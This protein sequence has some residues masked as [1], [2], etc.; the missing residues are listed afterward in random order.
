MGQTIL[1]IDPGDTTGYVL[2]H[3]EQGSQ[4]WEVMATGEASWPNLSEL[5]S[6][7]QYRHQ[8]VLVEY[9]QYLQ[10]GINLE[11]AL[12]TTGAVL[13]QVYRVGANAILRTPGFL[14]KGY[15]LGQELPVWETLSSQH[16]K[17]AL[18][19]ALVYILE[20]GDNFE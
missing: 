20:K 13:F 17:D 10:P 1:S 19:H 16:V 2:L 5:L 12:W 7:V 15:L 4:L 6:W 11:K 14:P 18:A 9:V 3:R 8:M